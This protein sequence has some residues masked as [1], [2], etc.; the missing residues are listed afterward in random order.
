MQKVFHTNRPQLC[1]KPIKQGFGGDFSGERG[2]AR[3]VGIGATRGAPKGSKGLVNKSLI[4]NILESSDSEFLSQFVTETM[5]SLD[6]VMADVKSGHDWTQMETI[7]GECFSKQLHH[8]CER[9]MDELKSAQYENQCLREELRVYKS[10]TQ[11]A[12]QDVRHVNCVQLM[13]QE[14]IDWLPSIKTINGVID[15]S[16]CDGD[17]AMAHYLK[18]YFIQIQCL[19]NEIIDKNIEC[20]QSPEEDILWFDT[21]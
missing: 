7:V 12:P 14:I 1:P 20:K 16:G 11:S 13:R 10:R 3:R 17:K 15:G 21:I 4:E 8:K 2:V 9:L 18:P 19:L 5:D 6:K